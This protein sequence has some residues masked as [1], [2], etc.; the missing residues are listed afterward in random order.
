MGKPADTDSNHHVWM[1]AGVPAVYAEEWLRD[2]GYLSPGSALADLTRFVDGAITLIPGASLVGVVVGEFS[3]SGE[4][5]IE[6]EMHR[7]R[8]HL[9]VAHRKLMQRVREWGDANCLG[10]TRT[11]GDLEFWMSKAVRSYSIV[12][13]SHPKVPIEAKSASCGELVKKMNRMQSTTLLDIL[14]WLVQKLHDRG[15]LTPSLLDLVRIEAA[16]RP[17]GGRSRGIEW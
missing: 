6:H 1:I 10:R 8:A 3:V 17:S 4:I 12:S 9:A 13:S 16:P 15:K 11:G 2:H 14:L 7:R 5:D